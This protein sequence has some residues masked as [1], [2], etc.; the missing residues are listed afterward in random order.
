[1]GLPL[2]TP[3]D[4]QPSGPQLSLQGLIGQFL[5]GWYFELTLPQSLAFLSLL[6]P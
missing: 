2:V 6:G 4:T 5:A 3:T 1:M